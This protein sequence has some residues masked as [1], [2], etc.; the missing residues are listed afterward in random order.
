M[1]EEKVKP[2]KLITQ[3]EY[4]KMKGLTRG[5]VNQMIKEKKVT[6]VRIKG[7]VLILMD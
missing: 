6:A 7:T 3:A 1:N 2:S 4:A 5:R